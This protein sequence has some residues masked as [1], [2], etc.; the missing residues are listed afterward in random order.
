MAWLWASGNRVLAPPEL[1]KHVVVTKASE[2]SRVQ[3][4]RRKAREER[5]LARAVKSDEP[6]KGT[7]KGE[8]GDGA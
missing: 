4:E 3:K 8:D 7:G 6:G 1:A 2:V 5:M